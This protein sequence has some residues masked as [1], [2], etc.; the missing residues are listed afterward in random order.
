VK[1][2]LSEWIWFSWDEKMTPPDFMLASVDSCNKTFWMPWRP[3]IT[4]F[5]L[6]VRAVKVSKAWRKENVESVCVQ[7]W[8]GSVP[9]TS[10]SLIHTWW[11]FR[12][13]WFFRTQ[14]VQLWW[15]NDT[16]WI[17]CQLHARYDFHIMVFFKTNLVQLGW[18]NDTTGTAG[19]LYTRCNCHSAWF[20]KTHLVQ[21]SN[22][23]M[24]PLAGLLVSL[25]NGAI[26]VLCD[27][28][29]HIWFNFDKKMIPL[30]LQKF[31]KLAG[32]SAFHLY[33]I[34][35]W[36]MVF[37]AN[38]LKTCVKLTPFKQPQGC[39]YTHD[40]ISALHGS[41]KHIGFNFGE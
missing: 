17:V 18:K 8:C 25:A 19:Q 30:A 6:A 38:V 5:K 11:N 4:N 20:F 33:S 1:H 14:V 27:S 7:S 12:T 34:R 3:S 37:I 35:N 36:A 15:K 39:P 10:R 16:A 23:N 32:K 9:T 13:V 31:W 26:S 2:C 28:W 29:K 22:K 41:A 21:L 40:V 24:I